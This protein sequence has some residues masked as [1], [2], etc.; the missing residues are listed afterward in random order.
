MELSFYFLLLALRFIFPQ[1]ENK[2]IAGEMRVMK[3]KLK[4]VC[5]SICVER[6]DIQ[7][8]PLP[9]PPP[10]PIPVLS[11]FIFSPHICIAF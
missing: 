4:A 8:V 9:P 3:K 5:G 10:P 6:D 2:E 1:K 11:S 7:G